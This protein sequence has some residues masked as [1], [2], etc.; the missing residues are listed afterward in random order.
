MRDGLPVQGGSVS[1][2]LFIHEKALCESDDVGAGTRIWAFAHVMKGAHVGRDCNICDHAFIESGAVV[3]D[4]VTVKNGVMIWDGVTIEDEVFIGPGVVFTN[5]VNPRAAF[6]KD[7]EAFGA[8]RVGRGASIGASATILCGLTVGEHAF[9]GAGAVVTRSVPAH[10]VVV[11][12]PARRVGW[13][14]VC[15]KK[16][17]AELRCECGRRFSLGGPTGGLTT[18]HTR[19]D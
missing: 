5:V 15:G 14:C 10:A 9:V 6:K 2:S 4:R 16:L 8:T 3:G 11:G 17:P 18:L 12:S 1:K 19:L 13:M 7:R